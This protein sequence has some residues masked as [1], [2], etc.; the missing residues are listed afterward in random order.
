[1]EDAM[2]SPTEPYPRV[3]SIL[4][5][6]ADWVKRYRYASGL[7]AELRHCGTDEVA[8]VARELGISPGELVD[9]AS[10]GSAAAD[11]L[12]KLL[13]ALGVDPAVLARQD[14]LAMRDLQRLCIT[15]GEKRRC[16]HELAA[17]TAAQH[18]RSYCP[19]AFTL[20]A[21]FKA[22]GEQESGKA[23]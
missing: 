10:R 6:I 3:E 23:V 11:L 19:N 17:G 1:M 21:L 4:D 22:E 9:L 15:C 18:Y 8:R 16:E 13:R 14:P 2:V 7:R 12:P 5:A 20:D